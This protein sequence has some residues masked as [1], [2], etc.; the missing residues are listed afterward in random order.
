MN[1]S[2]YDIIVLGA[3]PAGS[4]TANLL[5]R[6]GHRVLVLEKETFPRFHVG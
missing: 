6:A 4:T 5:A 1:H 3:G 2:T